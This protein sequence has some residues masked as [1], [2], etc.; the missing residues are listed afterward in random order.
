MKTDPSLF[1][2]CKVK[3]Y[4]TEEQKKLFNRYFDLFRFFYNWALNKEIDNHKAYLEGKSDIKFLS[5]TDLYHIFMAEREEEG[6]E[7]YKELPTH[8]FR[9]A[10]LN[11]IYAYKRFFRRGNRGYPKF[12]SAKSAKKVYQFRNEPYTFYFTDQYVKIPGLKSRDKVL[13]KS[14]H[15]PYSNDKD[16]TYYNGSVVF[17]GYNYWLCFSMEADRSYLLEHEETG[18]ENESIGI[19]LGFKK[20]AQLSTGQTYYHPDVHVL[21]RRR[22]KQQSRLD[23]MRNSR[24]Q[25]AR[26][27][28]S[29]LE[30]IPVSNNEKKLR[31]QFYKTRKRIGNIQKSNYHRITTEIANMYP[32]RIVLEDLDLAEMRSTKNKRYKPLPQTQIGLFKRF[33]EYKCRDRGIE[34]VYADR[35]F[36]STKLC[37]NCGH[38]YDLKGSRTYRCSCCGLVMDRDLNAAI[39]L[40]R[41]KG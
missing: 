9:K 12:K 37:S 1:I 25:K 3:L 14:H 18:Y 33:M 15:I 11:L 26:K 27:A 8:S 35:Y 39:N 19:D 7:W 36:P 38:K 40:S 21:E 23:K 10:I 30:D 28:T 2:G 31:Y 13:C 34:L 29:K 4:P 6:K 32:K 16:I 17:D 5:E 41:Y 24:F 20:L 22:R